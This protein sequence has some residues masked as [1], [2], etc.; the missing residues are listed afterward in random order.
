MFRDNPS[1]DFLIFGAWV[2]FVALMARRALRGGPRRPLSDRSAAA[3]RERFWS[4]FWPW[5]LGFGIM[6]VLLGGAGV[7]GLID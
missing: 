5:L 1:R 3:I 2:I 7:V 4:R 6:F